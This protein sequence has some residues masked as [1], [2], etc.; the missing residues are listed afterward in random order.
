M[1]KQNI[2]IYRQHWSYDFAQDSSAAINVIGLGLLDGNDMCC[3][4]SMHTD[5][6][7]LLQ[8]FKGP[9]FITLRG[10]EK[11]KGVNFGKIRITTTA[12]GMTKVL[13]MYVS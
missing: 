10:G 6:C 12:D 4:Q 2:I 8:S 7:N 3:N 5:C 9:Y 13:Y 1:H 11:W